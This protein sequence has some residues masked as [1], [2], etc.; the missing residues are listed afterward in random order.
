M[1]KTHT[2]SVLTLAAVVALSLACGGDGSSNAVA[3]DPSAAATPAASAAPAAASVASPPAGMKENL[4]LTKDSNV[5][6]LLEGKPTP[7]F[8]E[9]DVILG[10]AKMSAP[11]GE[12]AAKDGTGAFELVLHEG[13][14]ELHRHAWKWPVKRFDATSPIMLINIVPTR[15]M[16]NPGE[17]WTPGFAKALDGLSGVHDLTFQLESPNADPPVLAYAN[18]KYAAGGSQDYAALAADLEDMLGGKGKYAPKPK[19][20][21]GGLS[22]TLVNNCANHARVV[23]TEPSGRKSEVRIE[24]GRSKTV[25]V[26]MGTK[27]LALHAQNGGK[28]NQRV[29]ALDRDFYQGMTSKLCN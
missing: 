16:G 7:P 19:A 29:M 10:L 1:F 24:F 17:D 5:F 8:A 12:L 27:L 18:F 15:K 11:S 22:T 25:N 23:M 3:V 13:G 21:K 9:G 28:L 26:P 20:A 14:K 4:A 2:A 6:P